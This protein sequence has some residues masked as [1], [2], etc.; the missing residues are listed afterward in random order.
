MI[1]SCA[2]LLCRWRDTSAPEERRWFISHVAEC[3]NFSLVLNKIRPCFLPMI[4]NVYFLTDF[5]AT[6]L[7]LWMYHYLSH[8]PS[9]PLP[10]G[11][12][13]LQIVGNCHVRSTWI[14][15]THDEQGWSDP[16]LLPCLLC[17]LSAAGLF[18]ERFP[19]RTAGMRG[20][21]AAVLLPSRDRTRG[22]SPCLQQLALEYLSPVAHLFLAACS[23]LMAI[24][25][26][27]WVRSEEEEGWVGE[28]Q[29]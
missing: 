25:H 10:L 17:L 11:C 15:Q 9:L 19:S 2:Q 20:A 29:Q 16:F 1:P 14:C 3:V 7:L 6:A 23:A 13:A 8:L 22:Q 18:S 21:R 28:Q 5:H 4:R 24:C 26:H 27:W 12:G